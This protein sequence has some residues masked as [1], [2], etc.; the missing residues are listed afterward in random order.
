V[1]YRHGVLQLAS[2]YGL[3]P[4]LLVV[5]DICYWYSKLYFSM[6]ILCRTILIYWKKTWKHHSKGKRGNSTKFLF[7]I[8][9]KLICQ[10][11]RIINF[12]NSKVKLL[13]SKNS[14]TELK[15]VKWSSDKHVL[16]LSGTN[17]ITHETESNKIT[18]VTYLDQALNSP[19]NVTHETVVK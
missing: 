8:K 13:Y 18:T 9:L 2:R 5:D 14:E 16:N 12:T 11:N 6:K 3:Q 7:F 1:Y 19:N 10:S 17:K 4:C 15:L